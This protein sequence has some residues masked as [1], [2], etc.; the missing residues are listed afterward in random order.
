MLAP[1]LVNI[2]S[3][4]LAL[5]SSALAQLKLQA[6]MGGLYRMMLVR[7]RVQSSEGPC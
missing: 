5:I 6:C 2:A 3:T 1:M 4:S 7:Q